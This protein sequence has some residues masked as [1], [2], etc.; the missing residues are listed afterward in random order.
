[1]GNTGLLATRVKCFLI[2]EEARNV[3][4]TLRGFKKLIVAVEY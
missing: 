3:N 2:E 4:N 1:M